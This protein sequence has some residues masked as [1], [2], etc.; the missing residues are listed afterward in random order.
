[1]IILVSRAAPQIQGFLT[2]FEMSQEKMKGKFNDLEDYG[3]ITI[4]I[5]ERHMKQNGLWAIGVDLGGTKTEVARVNADGTLEQRIRFKTDVAGGHAA[6][7]AE[8]VAAIKDLRIN[9]KTAPAAVGVGV[10]GQIDEERGV[11]RFAPNLGWRDVPLGSIVSAELK[12]PVI[13]MND[14]RAATWGEWLHGAGMDCDDLV[15]LFAGTGIGGGVVSQ[16]RMMKGCTNTSGEIGHMTIDLHG[17]RCHCRNTGC[18]EALAGGWAIARNAQEAIE[19]DPFAGAALLER[20]EGIRSAVTARIVGEAAKAGD[21]L[22]RH[23][24]D[25][26]A[27]ALSAGAVTLVNAFNPCRLILG[28]GIIEGMPELVDRIRDGVHT[29]AL[30]TAISRLEVIPARLGEDAGVI[31]MAACALHAAAKRRS[32]KEAA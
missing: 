5:K 31:G 8:I 1:M 6:V 11:V 15:C 21:G 18:L 25:E 16:G 7:I 12:L 17:P 10:A 19:S 13:L 9:I 27:E 29:S 22:A 26:A 14:V 3:V 24:M 20:A 30:T 23:L 4:L 2:S 28:G 32:K